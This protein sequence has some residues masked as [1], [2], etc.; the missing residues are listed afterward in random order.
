MEISDTVYYQKFGPWRNRYGYKLEFAVIDDFFMLK[1][2]TPYR[3]KIVT[4][5]MSEEDLEY[6]IDLYN[7]D[8]RY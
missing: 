3:Q 6:K 7:Q 1:A 2:Y 5:H 4:Y 8:R